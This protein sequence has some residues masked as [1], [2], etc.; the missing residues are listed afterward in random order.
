M[1]IYG[2][3]SAT[4]NIITDVPQKIPIYTFSVALAYYGISIIIFLK[5]SDLECIFR[6]TSYLSIFIGT[7]ST[8]N[9]VKEREKGFG[10]KN[11][12]ILCLCVLFKKQCT[13]HLLCVA[14]PGLCFN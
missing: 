12:S 6:G 3:S 5:A 9:P 10:E 8:T 14:K 11:T 2:I 7:S 13:K 1:K 4:A